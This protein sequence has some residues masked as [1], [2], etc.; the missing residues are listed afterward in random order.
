MATIPFAVDK[1]FED[2]I[3]NGISQSKSVEDWFEDKSDDVTISVSEAADKAKK[4]LEGAKGFFDKTLG[5]GGKTLLK[6]LIPQLAPI[7]EIVDTVGR[8]KKYK[9]RLK[10]LSGLTTKSGKYSGTPWEKYFETG[11]EG[12]KGQTKSALEGLKKTDLITGERNTGLSFT[13]SGKDGAFTDSLTKLKENVKN[14]FGDKT[15]YMDAIPQSDKALNKLFSGIERGINAPPIP[16]YDKVPGTLSTAIPET[17]KS[18][19]KN[20]FNKNSF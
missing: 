10:E 11:M 9:K 8:Q 19:G 5:T 17:T 13:G 7:M 6:I 18:V 14:I 3:K 12:I 2:M 16:M 15:A 4:K 1:F 20:I